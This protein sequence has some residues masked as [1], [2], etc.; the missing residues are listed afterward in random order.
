MYQIPGLYRF[1]F[2]QEVVLQTHQYP[3]NQHLDRDSAKRRIGD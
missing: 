2:G 1:L 3:T